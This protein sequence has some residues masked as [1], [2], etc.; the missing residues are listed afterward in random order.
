MNR[1]RNHRKNCGKFSSLF[2]SFSS[3]SSSSRMI[4]SGFLFFMMII[5]LLIGLM[6]LG[7]KTELEQ[8]ETGLGINLF[9]SD[10]DDVAEQIKMKTTTNTITNTNTNK[11]PLLLFFSTSWCGYCKK[12]M[13]PWNS[14]ISSHC[15][16]V[17]SGANE[18]RGTT[19]SVIC[20]NIDCTSPDANAGEM[21]KRYKVNYYPFFVL[22]KMGTVIS[23]PNKEITSELFETFLKENVP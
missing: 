19:P 1:N 17:G 11:K 10:D 21:M 22:D 18:Y 23:F 8:F 5:I 15:T 14:F 16:S 20:Q 9:E 4:L 12:A 13:G 7:R 2:P 6:S 3:F